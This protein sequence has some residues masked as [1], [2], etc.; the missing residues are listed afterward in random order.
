MKVNTYSFVAGAVAL[1]ATALAM[2]TLFKRIVDGTNVFICVSKAIT[3]GSWS[4]TCATEVMQD[5][6][7]VQLIS[8]ADLKIDLTISTDPTI[9]GLSSSSMSVNLIKVPDNLPVPSFDFPVKDSSQ[10]DAGVEIARF[11]TPKSITKVTGSNLVTVVA[12]SILTILP[13][14]EAYFVTFMSKLLNQV[15]LEMTLKGN[16]NATITVAGGGG[17]Y[18]PGVPSSVSITGV[19]YSAP[20]TIQGCN[21]FIKVTYSEQSSFTK[22]STGQYTLTSSIKIYNPSQLV[23]TMGNVV[24]NTIDKNGKVVGITS[25]TGLSLAMGDNTVTAVTVFTNADVYEALITAGYTFTFQGFDGSST[26][27]VLA[28]ALATLTTNITVPILSPATPSTPPA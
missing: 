21:S 5:V 3:S 27:R 14:K 8:V 9:M 28:K 16:L 17:G 22:D 23:L 11:V 6:G 12:N 4:S 1:S 15:S 10:D 25:F 19:A 26:N 2:P 7:I 18:I 24:F 13:E 20:V